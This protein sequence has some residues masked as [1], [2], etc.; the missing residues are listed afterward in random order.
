MK[1]DKFGPPEVLKYQEIELPDLEPNQL[2]V[3]NYASS[4]NM[5]DIVYRSGMKAVFGLTRLSTGIFSPKQKV[6]GWDMAG[7]VVET[8]SEVTK[9]KA[10]DRVY[11]GASSGGYAQFCISRQGAI[12]EIP[13]EISYEQAAVLPMASLTALQAL[14]DAGEIQEGMD[15]LVYGASGGIGTMAVQF[16]KYYD[17]DV[18]GVASG[19]NEDLVRSLGV[20]DFIDYKTEDFTEK[21]KNYDL[22]V[23]A[24]GKIPS[25][26]WKKALK[27]AGIF[28]DIGSPS[29]SIMALIW[30]LMTNRFRSKQFRT[31]LT[32]YK[33]EDLEFINKIIQEE[34]LEIPIEKTFD[35]IDLPKAHHHYQTGR[36][37][38]KLA[39]KISHD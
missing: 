2:L 26:N 10:G 34:R 29:M 1:Y 24:V 3:K 9:F 17:C 16:S 35:L 18:T 4:V 22:I 11:G 32:E 23:D 15:V 38:G 14:R 39:I 36:T 20:D 30:R 28:V 21:D 7:E 25:K 31:I 12:A 13:E 8:G 33:T 19:R 6:L 27:E 37:R 5:T